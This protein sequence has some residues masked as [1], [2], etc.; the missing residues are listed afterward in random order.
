MSSPER[1]GRNPS[2]SEITGNANEGNRQRTSARDARQRMIGVSLGPKSMAEALDALPT[3]AEQADI[4]EIRLDYFEGPYD[5]ARLLRDRPLPVIV[6]NRPPREGG[7]CDQPDDER[8]AVLR[9]AAELGAEYVDVEWDAAT[10]EALV[11]IKAAGARVLVSRHSFSEMPGD[12]VDWAKLVIERGADVVKIVGMAHDVRDT[13]PVFRVFEQVDRPAI[14]IAMGEAGLPSRVLALRYDTCFLTYAT[15]GAGERVA[16]GQ[17]PISE[18]NQVFRAGRLSPRTAVYGLLGPHVENDRLADYNAWFERAGV[19]A[20]AVAFPA[21]AGGE[22]DAADIVAA[23][24][25]LPVAG[26][27]IHGGELQETVGVALDELAASACRQ[28]KVNSVTLR[29]ERLIGEWVESPAE[30]FGLWTGIDAPTG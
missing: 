9:R 22:V 11:P 30:Q 25:E 26:W 28:G 21:R 18:M 19:D 12:F 29:H 16:P 27:H 23:F 10:S 7:R 14:A 17:L 6:T 15:L 1:T 3:I 13:L 20:V 8:L 5:L 4:V 2:R 24:R